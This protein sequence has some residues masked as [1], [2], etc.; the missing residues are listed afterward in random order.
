MSIQAAQTAPPGGAAHT[1]ACTRGACFGPKRHPTRAGDHSLA[2]G[3]A[4]QSVGNHEA[5][6][7]LFSKLT[8]KPLHLA[9]VQTGGA[10]LGAQPLRIGVVLSGG[11]AAGQPWRGAELSAQAVPRCQAAARGRAARR[12]RPPARASS[13]PGPSP[14]AAT[15]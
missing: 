4:R 15:P 6:C 12:R 7:A 5:I 3:D 13:L 1:Q 14:L 10:A 2:D 8:A 11:Q 9:R